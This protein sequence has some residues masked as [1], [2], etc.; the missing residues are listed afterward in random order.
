[1]ERMTV[2][3]TR[4]SER[5]R[6]AGTKRMKGS[7]LIVGGYGEVGKVAARRLARLFPGSVIVAG[8]RIET[9]RAF[10]RSTDGAVRALQLDINN[11]P[12]P[13][14]YLEGVGTVVSSVK[15]SDDRIVRHCLERGI[16]YTEVAASFETLSEITRLSETYPSTRSSVITGV[17]LIPGLSGVLAGHLARFV[18]RIEEVGIHVM[19]GAGDEHGI[20]E[21]RYMDSLD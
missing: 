16:N 1:M 17:G 9:A 15:R 14:A 11:L 18:D 8:R 7:I 13:E 21:R 12:A 10:A 2:T 5:S 19:L 3:K 6:M 20:D 4:K